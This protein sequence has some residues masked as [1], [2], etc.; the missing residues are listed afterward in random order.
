MNFRE[1]VDEARAYADPARKPRTMSAIAKRCGIS[2]PHIYNLF[3]GTKTAPEWTV[4]KI[5]RGLGL[6]PGVVQRALDRSA[7]E[8]LVS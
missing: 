2:R 6:E 1:L 8:A 3:Y 7:A 4:H 5:A